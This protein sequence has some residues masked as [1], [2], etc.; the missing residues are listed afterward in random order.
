MKVYTLDNELVKWTPRGISSRDNRSK[1]GL[2]LVARELL[3]DKHPTVS[4]I[5]EVTIPLGRNKVAYLDFYIPLLQIAYEA[6]G[7][8]H[9]KFSAHFHSTEQ[10]FIKHKNRDADK[11]RW[12]EL[13]NIGLVILPYNEIESWGDLI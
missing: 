8:Q 6:H 1:S 9:Y 2:H 13:N 7:E 10:G 4:I 11:E 3:L 12:C 5:E